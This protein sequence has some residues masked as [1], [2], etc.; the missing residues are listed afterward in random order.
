MTHTDKNIYKIN[1][2][3]SLKYQ[4]DESDTWLAAQLS[5]MAQDFVERT[6][7]ERYAERVAEVMR[8]H[9]RYSMIDRVCLAQALSPVNELVV[10][11][12]WCSLH[13]GQN[14]MPNGYRC[15]VDPEGSLFQLKPGQMRVFGSSKR[16]L[17]QYGLEGKPPQ[18]SMR[19][20]SEMGLQSGMC[21]PIFFYGRLQGILFMNTVQEEYFH[22]LRDEDYALLSLIKMVAKVALALWNGYQPPLTLQLEQA[23]FLHKS[24]VF[25]AASF[26]HHVQ[27][28]LRTML[29]SSV[30]IYVD[31]ATQVQWLYSPMQ[32]AAA[33]V[34]A[35]MALSE[36][37]LHTKVVLR[38][39]LVSAPSGSGRNIQISFQHFLNYNDATTRQRADYMHRRLKREAEQIGLLCTMDEFFLTYSFP[40][41]LAYTENSGILYSV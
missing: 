20:I 30:S 24:E 39:E 5:N 2:I 38:L 37:M 32:L 12:S 16:I 23:E 21:L 27:E 11:S 10:V 14:L 40:L 15:F 3:K 19:Y 31:D 9:P 26:Q 25:V 36:L 1:F 7:M 6:A 18:R 4:F 28:L 33:I 29:G 41:D 8:G 34:S 22:H 13:V 17:E 35:V